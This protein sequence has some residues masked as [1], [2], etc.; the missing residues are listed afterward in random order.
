MSAF[1]EKESQ[2]GIGIHC[3]ELT[4]AQLL[5]GFDIDIMSTGPETKKSNYDRTN[6][7]RFKSRLQFFGNPVSIHPALFFIKNR[8]NYNLLHIHSHLPF[9]SFLIALFATLFRKDYVIT[10]H[11]LFSQTAP[12][13]LSTIWLNSFG[14][15][16]FKHA[17]RIFVYTDYE[18]DVISTLGIGRG[19]VLTI[20]N[21]IK[22]AKFPLVRNS[23][24]KFDVIT[25]ARYVKGKGIH[26]LI[27]AMYFS[28][29]RGHRINLLI[30]GDGPEFGTIQKLILDRRMQDQVMQIKSIPNDQM[31]IYYNLS[32]ILVLPSLTEGFPKVVLEALACGIPAL[33]GQYPQLEKI[34]L[35]GHD[36]VMVQ[37]T[38]ELSFAIEKMIQVSS[39]FD[40]NLI[41]QSIIQ[42][43]S[44][45]TYVSIITNEMRSLIK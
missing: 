23:K 21:G 29:I 41:R 36:V 5:E 13:K 1:C 45:K 35:L 9:L 33:T 30:V 43:N 20:P 26:F 19:R 34:E 4:Q 14:K 27:E 22:I 6:I 44:W 16:I 24:K 8:N 2:G 18:K 40:K 11:G 10:S 32:K 3:W 42:T 39:D 38:L 28:R 12:L 31:Y 37:N 15:F 17:V 25:V 7:F